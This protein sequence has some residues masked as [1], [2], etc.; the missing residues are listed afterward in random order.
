MRFLG[1]LLSDNGP[2]P[3]YNRPLVVD[4]S[5]YGQALAEVGTHAIGNRQEGRIDREKWT[6][7]NLIC[8]MLGDK[9]SNKIPMASLKLVAVGPKVRRFAVPNLHAYLY[10][11]SAQVPCF[12]PS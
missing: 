3:A 10:F 9:R 5:L 2:L 12:A 6:K 8:T 11:I 1:A 4:E 7:K